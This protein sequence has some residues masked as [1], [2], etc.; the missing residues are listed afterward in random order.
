[1]DVTQ[2]QVV[3]TKCGQRAVE[4]GLGHATRVHWSG[5]AGSAV[6][7]RVFSFSKK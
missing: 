3:D 5:D 1:M 6:L 7:Q 4:H 2:I